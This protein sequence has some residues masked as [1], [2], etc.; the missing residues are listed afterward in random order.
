MPQ[1][2]R[3][4]L[5]CILDFHTFGTWDREEEE[6]E[7]WVVEMGPV[8][9]KRTFPQMHTC[10]QRRTCLRCGKQDFRF[11]HKVEYSERNRLGKESGVCIH[12]KEKVIRHPLWMG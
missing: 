4:D 12:C 6:S 8:W 7:R 9:K 1:W 10:S 11:E 2:K 5:L 3:P